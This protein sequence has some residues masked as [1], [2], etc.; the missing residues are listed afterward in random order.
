MGIPC[1]L[2]AYG[3]DCGLVDLQ[4]GLSHFVAPRK[5]L[6]IATLSQSG[7]RSRLVDCLSKDG[8][9]LV[10]DIVARLDFDGLAVRDGRLDARCV[11]VGRGGWC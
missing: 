10:V 5:Y 9:V 3:E 8:R 2:Y 1:T 11:L 4:E 7:I 6:F